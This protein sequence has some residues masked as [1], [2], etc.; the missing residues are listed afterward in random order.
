MYSAEAP[1]DVRAWPAP[2]CHALCDLVLRGAALPA[3]QVPP[4][5]WIRQ[6]SAI[7]EQAPGLPEMLAT[8]HPQSAAPSEFVGQL[9]LVLLKLV[10]APLGPLCDPKSDP[11]GSDVS[12]NDGQQLIPQLTSEGSRAAASQLLSTCHVVLRLRTLE[13]R[14]AAELER[15][16]REA[17]YHF[18]YGLSHELNNPLANIVA[19]AELLASGETQPHRRSWL[20]TISSSALRGAEMLRDLMLLARPPRL[21]L[22]VLS[23]DQLL[24]DLLPQARAWSEPRQVELK[25]EF[26]ARPQARFD[27]TAL[28]EAVWAVLRNA[29][30]AMPDGGQVTI[31]LVAESDAPALGCIEIA[32]QGEG[33]SAIAVAHSFDPYY[34]GR[35]AGRGLGLGLA[36]AQ[37][38]IKLHGGHL[39]LQNRAGGGCLARIVIPLAD[40]GCL[41]S[42]CVS[43]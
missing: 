32:D 16:K 22:A 25:L 12:V 15:Q 19:R 41:N 6:L 36:K 40:N 30:E 26:L 27:S 9:P 33:M 13:N 21:Q 14:F 17:I 8:L 2:V 18:A 28:T 4:T 34:S 1:H 23:L 29:I 31:K 7:A 43:P 39:H 42:P 38:I 37:R 35:E 10:P 20:A 3:D 5:E 24:S 11:S